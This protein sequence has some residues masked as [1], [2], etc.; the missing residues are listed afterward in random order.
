MKT[1]PLLFG[2]TLLF[3]GWQTK[4]LLFAVIMAVIL[5]GVRLI[6]F[7]WDFSLSELERVTDVCTLLLIGMLVY[8]FMSRNL[9]DI[10]FILLQWLPITFFPLLVCQCYSTSGTI[11]MRAL[12]LMLRRKRAKIR[13]TPLAVNLTYPYVILC[14]LS[15]GAANVRNSQFYF[16][17]FVLAIW[18]LWPLRS[19]RYSPILWI[20]M[21]VVAGVAGYAGHIQINRFQLFLERNTTILR[22]FTGLQQ[23]ADPYQ[24]STAIGDIGTIKLSNRVL[25]R[26][27][28]D[29][30]HQLSLLF[31]EASYDTYKR[32]TWY[33]AC[34]EF[35]DIQPEEDG[36]AWKILPTSTPSQEGNVKHVTVSSYLT[37][38]E[39]IL[40]L[41]TGT[42][43][44]EK[45]PVGI[46]TVNQ[47]GVLKVEEGPGLISYQAL[48]DAH[49]SADSPPTDRD[50]VIPPD[51]IP[52]ITKLA[53]ELDLQSKSPD[54]ILQTIAAFFQEHFSYSLELPSQ[55]KDTITPLANFLFNARMGHCEYFATA[56]VLLLRAA[57]IPARY[58][59]G[60]SLDDLDKEGRWTL[61][62]GK[63]AHAWT[64]VYL[65]GTW[66]DFDTTPPSWRQIEHATVS[67][68]EWLSDLWSKWVFAFS[69][70]R[71]RERTGGN[72][73]YLVLLLIPLLLI[74]VWKLYSKKRVKRVTEHHEQIPTMSHSPGSDSEFYLI[75]HCMN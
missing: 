54:D 50:L 17:L 64:L 56:T 49:G 52:V 41:P 69:E 29:T 48:F 26:V 62:R 30:R 5:E 51:E 75:E 24:S 40:K 34:S 45:L 27:K 63:D 74:L 3:W 46:M 47:F 60:Y 8:L 53:E 33:A 65:N 14:I 25:F 7:R 18:A 43:Q 11:D 10:S 57:G 20:S 58:A 6:P 66:H 44:I 68:F 2:A 71:W 31:R 72:S 67:P 36:T 42:F 13:E 59:V 32:S 73:K 55:V 22:W 28:P 9:F 23:D 21:L 4:L 15:A 1:L 38:G 16:G 39:G 37:K 19:R 70:W 35:T 12:F 61:V